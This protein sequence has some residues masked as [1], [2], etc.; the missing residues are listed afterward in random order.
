MAKRKTG[1]DEAASFGRRNFLKGATLAGAGALAVPIKAQAQ[2]AAPPPAA[3]SIPAAPNRQAERGMPRDHAGETQSSSG[4]DFM[5]D[6]MRGLGIEH[7]AAFCGSSFRG[8]HESLINY[9]C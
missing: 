5:V 7:V 6:V 4:G 9:A 2:P 1:R 3:P 8:L